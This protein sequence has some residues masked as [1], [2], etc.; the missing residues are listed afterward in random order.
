MFFLDF[1]WWPFSWGSSSCATT[2]SWWS[3][4]TM[5]S[6]WRSMPFVSELWWLPSFRKRTFM[7][8]TM[9]GGCTSIYWSWVSLNRAVSR[10]CSGCSSRTAW[11]SCSFLWRIG[12]CHWGRYLILFSGFRH[13]KL[14]TLFKLTRLRVMHQWNSPWNLPRCQDVKQ[15]EY[16]IWVQQGH[17]QEKG[18]QQL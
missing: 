1:L 9:R 3:N 14:L 6:S 4:T 13:L 2:L 7:F 15:Y 8:A 10:S 12:Q 5:T 18:R 11:R 17:C 16:K